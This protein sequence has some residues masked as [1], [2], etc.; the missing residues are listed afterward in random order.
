MKRFFL[1]LAVGILSGGAVFFIVE[2]K[3]KEAA[4]DKGYHVGLM[5]GIDTGTIVGIA[6]GVAKVHSEQ[7]QHHDSVAAVEK[8]K[9][10]LQ[11]AAAAARKP[12]KVD[13]P[14]QNWHVID[15]K[16]DRPVVADTSK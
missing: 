10:A 3:I 14:I 5:K 15:G 8:K 1:G 11:K 6:Q 13:R 12:V 4:F 16:I 2:S 9:A 7:K